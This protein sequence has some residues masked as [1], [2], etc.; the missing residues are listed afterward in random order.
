M[1]WSHLVRFAA[2]VGCGVAP[3]TA[4]L[5]QE[6]AAPAPQF[7]EVVDVQLVNVEV[8]VSD[9]Q[10]RPV[11]GLGADAFEV[12]E[13]GERVTVEFF[14][15]VANAVRVPAASDDTALSATAAEAP[16]APDG[17][18]VEPAHLVL[19]FDELH[20]G[21]ASRK[22]VIEDL[23]DFLDEGGFPAERV[24]VLRQD[25]NL[26]VESYFGSSREDLDFVLARIG[27]SPGMSA[28]GQQAKR[29]AVQ[30]LN[31]LWQ[32]ARALTSS[33]RSTTEP[34]PCSWFLPRA[35]PEVE[36]HA[37]TTRDQVAATLDHLTTAVR[38]LAAQPGVKTLLYVSDALE[39]VPGN[40]LKD[41]ITGFCPAGDRSRSL[42]P[43]EELSGAFQELTRH[44]NA[45]RVTIYA[46]Q[47]NGLR[48]TFLSSVEQSSVDFLGAN[49]FNSSIREAQRDGLAVLADQTGGRAIFNRSQFGGE[50]DQIAAEM[51]SYYSLAYRPPHGGDG[52]QHTI[53]VRVRGNN[54]RVRHRRGYRDKSAD[55]RLTEQLD[56]A[57][58]LGLVENSLDVR[59]GAGRPRTAGGDRWRLPLHVI[60]PAARVTFLPTE[61][62]E[63]AQIKVQV[64]GR[65]LE[66]PATVRDEKTFLVDMPPD[67]E[68]RLLNLNF[69][70]E[71]P[72]GANLVAVAVRDEATRETTFVSTTLALGGNGGARP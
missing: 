5:A 45:N 28:Q 26:V 55:L 38:F 54:L 23:R 60:V 3:L 24:L 18:P 4:A 15:E 13:D 16:E 59:L 62:G 67:R 63:V 46:L 20:L 70:L 11:T 48:S 42:S 10:G 2:I 33:G 30:R 9:R 44:A 65:H 29:L 53:S 31:D 7:S 39:R 56:G 40:D 71:M 34:A 50:L 1:T 25:R 64:A 58:Y 49:P 12:H 32:E 14:S 69:N 66:S 43:V 52:G 8:R 51:G 35:L 22:Q 21:P 72:V 6:A 61:E 19:Y 36:I 27:T 57:L 17:A 47:T 68:K 37:R 41:L